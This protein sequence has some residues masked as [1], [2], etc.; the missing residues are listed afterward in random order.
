MGNVMSQQSQSI[1][2]ANACKLRSFR[3]GFR[4]KLLSQSSST[5]TPA[6]EI[7]S[8]RTAH[9]N[10]RPHSDTSP[11]TNVPMRDDRWHSN[12]RVSWHIA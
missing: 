5:R 10:E 9:V 8:T 3:A 6:Q 1:N 4:N 12:L 2:Q 11:T 7:C